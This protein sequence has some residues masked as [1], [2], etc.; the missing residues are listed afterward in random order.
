LAIWREGAAEAVDVPSR[1]FLKDEV[2]VALARR[3]PQNLRQLGGVRGFPAPLLDRASREVLEAVLRGMAVPHDQCPTLSER[4]DE[5]PGEKMSA[6]LAAAVGQSLCLTNGLAHSLFA[7]RADYQELA[8]W[9]TDPARAPDAAPPHL[10]S[11]WRREFA[12]DTLTACLTGK[13]SL[14][15]IPGPEGP[16]LEVEGER[17]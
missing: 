3:S 7:S 12:G 13:T 10:L 11:G 17:G 4:R 14:R 5:R 8:E 1:T 9:M 2:L 16:R 15:I 6:D